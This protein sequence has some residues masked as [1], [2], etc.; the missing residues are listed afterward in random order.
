MNI[1]YLRNFYVSRVTYLTTPRSAP[2]FGHN[3][4]CFRDPIVGLLVQVVILAK[5]CFKR[6]QIKLLCAYV[7]YLARILRVLN[8]TK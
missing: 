6:H 3:F 8:Y 2:E 5:V 1:N 7:P 4:D